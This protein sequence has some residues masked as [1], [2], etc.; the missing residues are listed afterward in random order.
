MLR[1][2]VADK[3]GCNRKCPRS[4][5]VDWKGACDD[6]NGWQWVSE[7]NGSTNLDGSRGSRV[8]TCDPV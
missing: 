7:S 3:N 4:P 5:T 1:Q 8:N 2:T 6:D